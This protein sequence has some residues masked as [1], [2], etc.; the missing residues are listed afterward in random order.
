MS[1]KSLKTGAFAQGI[2]K[3]SAVQMEELDTIRILADGRA[4]AYAL[5]GETLV[6]G[7]LVIQPAPS[8]NAKEETLAA[9]AAV[10][11]TSISVT[12]GTTFVA[13]YFK[14]GW[15]YPDNNTGEGN[16]YRV[17]GHAA[18]STITVYLKEPIRSA[19]TAGDTTISA[20][21]N[22]QKGVVLSTFA[23]TS[24][25]VGVP[26]IDVTSGY[27][28]WNQVSGPALVWVSGTLVI[29]NQVG[30]IAVAGAVT[31]LGTSDIIGSLGVA[32]KVQTTTLYGLIALAIPG[33]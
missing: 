29:G 23:Q 20:V 33:Y 10:G 6:P 15:I 32:M 28:F 11:A 14:D 5:A 21:V 2:Y 13:D 24:Q 22:R 4:F 16:L 9:S 12:F 8:D 31:P 1:S 7:K 17:K 27:Y 25:I 3:Q 26:P 19:I 18:G 30:Q